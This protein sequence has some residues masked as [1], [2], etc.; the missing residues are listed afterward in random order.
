MYSFYTSITDWLTDTSWM[1]AKP[2]VCVS[3][4]SPMTKRNGS[5]TAFSDDLPRLLSVPTGNAEEAQELMKEDGQALTKEI[6]KGE[7]KQNASK[8][9][10]TPS[11]R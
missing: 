1:G 4:L 7:Y 11:M 6:A 8:E 2:L 5:I 10:I 9:G 3:E